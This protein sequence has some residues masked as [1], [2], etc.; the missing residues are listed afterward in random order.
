MTTEPQLS[1]ASFSGPL[2]V[3]EQVEQRYGAFRPALVGIDLNVA[4]GEFIVIAGPG[5]CGKSVLLRLLAGLERPAAG[6]IRIAG[7]DIAGMRPRVR[8]HLRRSIGI[9]PPGQ[10]LLERRS[11]LH[12]VA[13][14]AWV[15]GAAFDEGVR[16]A[17]AALT[18]VGVEI[19]RYG[20][21]PCE[22]LPGGLRHCVALARALVNRP[23]LLLLDDLLAPLDDPSATRVLS[24]IDQFC[25]A[26]VTAIATTHAQ[27]DGLPPSAGAGEAGRPVQV[28]P[29]RVRT[30]QLRDGRFGS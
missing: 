21:M 25:A 9:L 5:G 24:V 20:T 12:N 30:L 28:W 2:L 19:E 7:E 8:T 27:A 16:R 18:L 29:A 3:L 6:R 4:R 14:A 22:Q 15:A 26:G 10:C 17:Q 1:D 11:V 13:L 23:A